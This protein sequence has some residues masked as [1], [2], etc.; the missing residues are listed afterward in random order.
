MQL[1]HHSSISGIALTIIC[2][3]DATFR[4]NVL[5]WSRMMCLVHSWCIF[6]SIPKIIVILG[7]F[8]LQVLSEDLQLSGKMLF[9]NIQRL[10]NLFIVGLDYKAWLHIYA[11]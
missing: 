3:L 6:G 9:T 4:D 1:F 2:H 8:H 5:I 11:S 10:A 7:M